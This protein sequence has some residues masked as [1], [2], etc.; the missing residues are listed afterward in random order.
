ML[1][2]AFETSGKV[3]T[4]FSGGQGLEFTQGIRSLLPTATLIKTST[5]IAL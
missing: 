2:C 5:F 4:V 3:S 1:N